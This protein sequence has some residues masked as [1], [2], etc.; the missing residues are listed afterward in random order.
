MVPPPNKVCGNSGLGLV[1]D[2]EIKRYIQNMGPA[3]LKSSST[4][5]IKIEHFLGDSAFEA[6]PNLVGCV[7]F[8]LA[9]PMLSGAFRHTTLCCLRGDGICRR[10]H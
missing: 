6:V 3:S 10:A 5:A 2:D 1:P 7:A 4:E 9:L 8:M